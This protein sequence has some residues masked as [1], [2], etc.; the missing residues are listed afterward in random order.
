[1][2]IIDKNALNLNSYCYHS[3]MMRIEYDLTNLD[4]NKKYCFPV[5]QCC[6]NYE[7]KANVG[8]L[9]ED[10]ILNN[11]VFDKLSNMY[12]KPKKVTQ[13][14]DKFMHKEYPKDS[15]KKVCISDKIEN[16]CV[17]IVN[18]CNLSCIMCH[19]NFLKYTVNTRLKELYFLLLEQIKNHNLDFIE[20]TVS[21]EPFYYKKETFE[22]LNSL[23]T[24]DCK[25]I[26][27]ISNL[28]LLNDEDIE[29][30]AEI[31][32]R[33]NITFFASI[34]SINEETYK[35]IRKNNSFKKVMHNLDK[36]VEKHIITGVNS[37]IMKENLDELFMLHEYFV[38][39]KEIEFNPIIIDD[40][41]TEL[42]QYIKNSKIYKDYLKTYAH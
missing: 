40:G 22:Y 28:T 35:K 18:Y 38:N 42:G 21:G 37:V 32:E 23:T 20:L 2:K 16:I 7:I 34:D 4:G 5:Y 19:N 11:Q 12:A 33:I 15:S 10:D 25:Q 39:I 30:L 3:N 27:I 41:L 26:K 24:K 14:C 29:K 13:L 36:L 31:K 17:S 8:Y 9:T 1:M 6:A